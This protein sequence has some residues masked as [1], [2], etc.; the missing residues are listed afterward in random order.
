MNAPGMRLGGKWRTVL[1]TKSRSIADAARN[2]TLPECHHGCLHGRM[3]LETRHY[4]SGRDGCLHSRKCLVTGRYQG[5]SHACSPD[6]MLVGTGR[7]QIG[8]NAG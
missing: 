7:Y 4:H 8:R 3:F 2:A 5:G 6:W 1:A